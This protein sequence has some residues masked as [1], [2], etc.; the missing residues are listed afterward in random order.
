MKKKPQADTI[1]A[2]EFFKLLK[3]EIV[4]IDKSKEVIKA[5]KK[6][7]AY[8][9]SEEEK[10]LKAFKTA[11]NILELECIDYCNTELAF[12]KERLKE[13]IMRLEK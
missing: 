8:V 1:S 11:L 4:D 12:A 3:G 6:L 10:D 7:E 2:E 5:K 9:K 13:L